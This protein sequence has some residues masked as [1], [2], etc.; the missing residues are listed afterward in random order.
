MSAKDI[1]PKAVPI[2][3]DKQRHLL[4]DMNA[5]CEIEDKLGGIQQAFDILMNGSPKGIR[6]LLWAGLIHEDEELTEKQVGAMFGFGS[7]E[8]ISIAIREAL[9]GSMPEPKNDEPS[10]AEKK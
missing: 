3:L 6:T 4:Y 10:P 2:Q 8:K 1:R 5:F 9:I 7:I